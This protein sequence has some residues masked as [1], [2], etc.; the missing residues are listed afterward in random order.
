MKV[1]AQE[2]AQPMEDERRCKLFHLN[3]CRLGAGPETGS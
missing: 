1:E 2:R 3:S